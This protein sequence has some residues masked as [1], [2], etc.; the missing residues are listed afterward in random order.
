MHLAEAVRLLPKGYDQE[1]NAVEMHFVLAMTQYQLGL[2]GPCT[3]SLRTVLRLAPTH[4]RANY[5]MAMARARLGE[6]ESARPF[7]EQAV[8][9]ESE[10]AQSP[11]F[12]D[13]L[14]A[15]YVQQGAYGPALKAA[16]T[17]L[18]PGRPG[19]A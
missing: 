12:Y 10:L 1:Y 8:R 16:E 5:A 9:G 17:G 13:V 3:N 7:F 18:P 15:N 19:R 2:W 14:S 6:T 4:A 11:D